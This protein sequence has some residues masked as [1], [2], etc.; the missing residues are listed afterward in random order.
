MLACMLI[1]GLALAAR[2]AVQLASYTKG[3][4][5]MFRALLCFAVAH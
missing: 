4:V 2:R 3:F 1:S 5:R